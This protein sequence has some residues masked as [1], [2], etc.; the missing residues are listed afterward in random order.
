MNVLITG[1]RAPISVEYAKCLTQHGHRVF[2][3]DSLNWPVSKFSPWHEGYFKLPAPARNFQAFETAI[4][5]LVGTLRID[6]VIPTSEE[7]FWLA[8]ISGLAPVLR[9]PS[10]KQLQTLHHKGLFSKVAQRIGYG[11][12]HAVELSTLRDANDFL[13]KHDSRDYVLKPC[14]SRF[15]HKVKL[16][17]SASEV[18]ALDFKRT[19]LAQTRVHGQE[20]CVYAIAHEGQVCWLSAYLPKYRLAD[21]ASLYF[22]P[23]GH[24]A[25]LPFV[26]RLSKELNLSGQV[27]FDVMLTDNGLVAL[28]C[29]PRGTSGV[30]LA[31]QSPLGWTRALLH[32]EAS[33]VEVASPR[34]LGLA[35]LMYHSLRLRAPQGQ[36]DF[37]RAKDV[38]SNADIPWYGG[39]LPA[40]E[41]AVLAASDGTSLLDASTSDF[42][43]NGP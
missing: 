11:A 4:R 3:G 2:L 12:P 32:G 19:W 41:L 38:L 6:A 16:S 21:G 13:S 31:A 17:P 33:A 37:R 39:V 24:P 26:A 29:N 9:A 10:F 42:E 7:V 22:E 23:F 30:H 8:Q 36:A 18:R 20:A 5:E 28:E 40:L 25:L 27:S 15:G 34:M 35:M 43:W 1:A 14:Y